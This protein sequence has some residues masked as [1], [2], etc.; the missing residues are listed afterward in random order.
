M[1]LCENNV[2]TTD[3]MALC[4]N[5]DT[6]ILTDVPQLSIERRDLLRRFIWLIDE[7]YNNKIHLY[8]TAECPLETLYVMP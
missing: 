2:G 3:F 6:L 4:Q 5:I 8:M 1:D 7:V